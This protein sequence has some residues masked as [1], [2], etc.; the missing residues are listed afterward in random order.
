MNQGK[1]YRN[2]LR[3]AAAQSGTGL[4]IKECFEKPEEIQSLPWIVVVIVGERESVH[5]MLKRW[6]TS[7]VDVDRRGKPCLE[8][9]V[10]LLFEGPLERRRIIER[11]DWESLN[12]EEGMRTPKRDLCTLLECIGGPRWVSVLPDPLWK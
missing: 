6:R 5:N 3:R 10:S 12:S 2:W 7:R 9:Q 4:L 11:L 1:L 8:R